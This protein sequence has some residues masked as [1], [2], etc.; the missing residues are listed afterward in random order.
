[1]PTTALK[2]VVVFYDYLTVLTE[3][4]SIKNGFML[5]ELSKLFIFIT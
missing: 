2:A 5:I 3:F 1:M 4:K